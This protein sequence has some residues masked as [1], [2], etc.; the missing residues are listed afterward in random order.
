MSYVQ[1]YVLNNAVRRGLR[2]K[3]TYRTITEIEL[4]QVLGHSKTTHTDTVIIK[5]EWKEGNVS[6]NNTLNTFYGVGYNFIVKDHSDS[7]R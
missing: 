3:Y 4:L 5:K 6:F 2:K 1:I 7:E